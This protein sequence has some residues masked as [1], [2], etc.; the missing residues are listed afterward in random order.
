MS[1]VTVRIDAD[2]RYPDYHLTDR[3]YG[4]E[5]EVEQEALD[6]WKAAAEAYSAAQGEMGELMEA[7]EDVAREKAA[8]AK[9]EKEAAEKA[10]RKRLT[11]ERRKE[12]HARQRREEAMRAK[13]Q[14]SDG[15]LYDADGKPVAAVI[16]TSTGVRLEP[17]A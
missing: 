11:E 17:T 5:V 13:I 2:E 16:Q 6:R 3:D 8:Q 4:Y 9:A 10:E 1:K 7:A 12:A 14:E 15:V